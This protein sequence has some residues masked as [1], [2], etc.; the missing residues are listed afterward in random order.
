MRRDNRVYAEI[1]K[2]RKRENNTGCCMQTVANGCIQRE[3]KD[4]MVSN[5]VVSSIRYLHIC[6]DTYILTYLFTYIHTYISV[7]I[8]TYLHICLHTY[9]L[10]YLFTYI[11]TY[12]SV[13]IHTYLHICFDTYIHY[14]FSTQLCNHL[15]IANLVNTHTH[16][17]KALR[18]MIIDQIYLISS[19]RIT[20]LDLQIINIK[21]T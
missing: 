19:L 18:Q 10:T 2:E 3:S 7:Y 16:K 12:I 13:Y 20:G 1:E 15:N 21:S 17:G 6:F 8:H 9:I 11:H 5:P 4:C 14:V